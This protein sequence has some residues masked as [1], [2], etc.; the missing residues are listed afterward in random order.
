MRF[1]LISLLIVL[2]LGF[3]GLY[4]LIHWGQA[5]MPSPA[6]LRNIAPPVKTTIYD[7]DSRVIGELYRE[8]RSYVPLRD[9]PRCM[10]DAILAIEDRRFYEHWG[11]DVFRIL[12]AAARNIMR[13]RVSQGGST[14]TQQLARNLFLT[15]D[16]TWQRKIKE[17]ILAL[18]IEQAYS[19]DE[20]LELYLNQIYFGDGAY[21][22]ESAAHR[23]FG[24]PARDLTLPEAAL[25][26]GLPRNPRDYTPRRSMEAAK[27]RRH[28]VLKA[29]LDARFID[30]TQLAAADATPIRVTD[31]AMAGTRAP[32]FV[33]TVRQYLDEKY[34]SDV[35]Y[36]AG[37]KVYTT[38]D[39]SLQQAAEAALEKQLEWVAD[40]AGHRVRYTA[41]GVKH[42]GAGAPSQ[43]HYLQGAALTIDPRTGGVLM[44][45]GGR[46]YADS[47][48]NRALQ[49]VRQPGSTFK[50][51]I[52]L[53]ALENGHRPNETIVDEPTSFHLA[54][55]TDWRPENYDPD[56]AGTVTLRYALAHSINVPAAKLLDAI[57]TTPVIKTARS[58]GLT[59]PIPPYLSIALGAAEV[60]ME[61]I[62]YA[63]AA[64]A[65]QGVLPQ[66]LMVTKVVDR[67]GVVLEENRP[68]TRVVQEA[69]PL[70][71]LTTMLQS[72]M[73]R[74][75]GAK[76]RE[77]GFR[78][79]CAGKSGTTND[80]SDAWF[81]GYTP[82]VVT[83]VWVGFD[84]RKPIGARMTG[85]AAA[86]PAWTDIM[87]AATANLPE[88]EFTKP[89]GVVTRSV[90]SETGELATEHCPATESEVFLAKDA[91]T[92]P[93]PKHGGGFLKRLINRF[94]Q[95]DGKS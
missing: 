56:F 88:K 25:L 95:H 60:N 50:P 53:T 3:G 69:A 46:D 82:D 44:M 11:L 29:M 84:E 62:T 33:E 39:L 7:R 26:A 74:G 86:L 49:A 87:K 16:Q 77:Y 13:G 47:R 72:V 75:T 37:L 80:N 5:D 83:M 34:G 57:G 17:Q 8:N 94:R 65:T 23:Y 59:T 12:G 58:L 51:F 15:M 30:R 40:K 67:D 45:I 4:A 31:E 24:K 20:I 76:A 68:R 36:T 41:G 9:V 38:L 63:Y 70:Y 10:I 71:V 21:G 85:S 35:V 55:G 19:K 32:Y 43:T 61:E 78:R 64:F 48:F 28:L 14:I 18:R 1:F 54:D 52:Y 6:R 73:D 93:C 89:E 2:G 90:C 27:R 81:I 66:P 92:E 22:V 42:S 91:P 79:P